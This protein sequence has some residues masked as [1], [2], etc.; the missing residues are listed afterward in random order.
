[1][2][3][4]ETYRVEELDEASRTYLREAR[5]RRGHG[6][7]GL[8]V[9]KN[10]PL[11]VISLIFGIGVLIATFL[12]AFPP[13]HEPLAEA[14]LQTGGLLL[15]GWCVL[16]AFRMWGAVSS[17][18]SLGHFIFADSEYL[19]E[20]NGSTVVVTD[21][22]GVI[23]ANGTH[24]SSNEGN[25][26]KTEITIWLDGGTKTL[27]VTNQERAEQLVYFLSVLPGLR[28]KD[29]S[30]ED[31]AP[32]N[33]TPAQ[34]GAI[35][36]EWARGNDVPSNIGL[37]RL[38][39]DVKEIPQPARTGTPSSGL[40]QCLIILALGVGGVFLFKTLNLPWRDDAIFERIGQIRHEPSRAPSRRYLADARNTRHR[41]ERKRC[42]IESTMTPWLGSRCRWVQNKSPIRSCRAHSPI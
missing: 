8:F 11:P 39:L 26:T 36:S 3:I 25:Y 41:P 22:F 30:A 10:N 20:C 40:I 23:R 17:G 4:S 29:A 16:A 38:E 31:E 12:I 1:M 13:I 15:G 5:E 27:N 9:P 7:P 18:K 32:R 14:M 35:A 2:P 42:W 37:D 33:R 24:H 21:L 6:L 34:I 19:W 28:Q